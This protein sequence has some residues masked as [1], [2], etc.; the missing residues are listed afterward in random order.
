MLHVKQGCITVQHPKV[1]DEIFLW[2]LFEVV[3]A[4]VIA[5]LTLTDEGLPDAS[6]HTGYACDVC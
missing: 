3:A 4:K 6:K 5:Q 2:E 1:G